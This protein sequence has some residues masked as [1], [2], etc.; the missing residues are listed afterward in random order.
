MVAEADSIIPPEHSRRLLEA[1]G[2]PKTWQPIGGV[3]HNGIDAHEEYW[4][5]IA[6]IL[7]EV[8]LGMGGAGPVALN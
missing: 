6:G 8:A 4:R 5:G 2:G 7:G 3:G 1:W